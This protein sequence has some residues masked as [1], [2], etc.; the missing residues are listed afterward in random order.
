MTAATLPTQNALVALQRRD[1]S[2]LLVQLSGAWHLHHGMPSAEELGQQLAG[3]RQPARVVVAAEVESWDSSI[4]TFLLRVAD[5]CRQA[6]AALD[7]GGLPKGLRRMVET[8]E[9]V[10]EKASAAASRKPR[11][12]LERLGIWGI[13]YGHNWSGSLNFLGQVSIAF[14]HWMTAR[15]RWRRV[16]LM[17]A[18]QDCGVHA[19]GIVTLISYLVGIILAFMGAIQLQQFGAAIFVADLVGIAMVREMGAMMTAIIMA[20][21]TG[22]SFAAQ[23][24]SMK[25]SQE[26]DAFQTMGVSPVEFLVLPRMIGLVLMMP[27]L[28]LYADLVGILGGA[29]IG[30]SMLHL[31]FASYLRETESA[32][33]MTMLVG[34]LFKSVVY[35][36]LVGL[37]GCLRGFECGTSSSAV[38]DAATRAVVTGIVLV[39]CA[40]GLFAFV[41]NLLGI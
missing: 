25:V 36:V 3:L 33:T 8:A 19:L 31:S 22:A 29:T 9:A 30:T 37:A 12:F 16:D 35:G 28:C 15:A 10:P 26:I 14:W 38:G 39:V 6:G 11:P 17:L 18:I 13:D 32:V 41:F 40:C 5:R 34:G 21:R 7:L 4:L 23:L 20:G 1:D 24:G 27:L 2:T